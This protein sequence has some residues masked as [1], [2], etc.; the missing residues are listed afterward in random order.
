MA[1]LGISAYD[2]KGEFI[3]LSR[4]AGN[5][6]D[7]MKELTPEAR[8]AAMGVIFGSDAVRAANVLYEQ[9]AEGI[10]GWTDKVNS[11]GYA[12]NTAAIAQDN[13]AGDFEKL[14]GSLD[15][16]FLKSASGANGALRGLA[17][18]AEDLV[19]AIGKIPTPV[20]EAGLGI[21][22]VVGGAALLGGA[23]LTLAPRVIE[24]VGAFK[25]LADSGSK[26]P[27]M[28]GKIGKAAGLASVALIGLQVA[29]AIFTEKEV[30][31]TEEFGQALLKV[32]KAGQEIDKSGLDGAFQG[33][34]KTFGEEKVKNVNN[35][36]DAVDQLFNHSGYED[37]AKSFDGF[38]QMIGAGISP[39]GE[40]EN[41]F[42]GLGE[43]MGGLTR[44]G[45]ADTAAKSFALLSA[46][47]EKN[48]KT[49]QDALEK[50]PAYKDALL[51][52]ATAAGVTLDKYQLMDLAL[53]VIPEVMKG[54]T[55]ATEKYT[56]ASG[57]SQPV[58]EEM[59]KALAEVGLSAQGV[60]TNLDLLLESM[61]ATGLLTQSAAD[62][63][64]AYQDQLDELAVS[65]DKV[66]A[67]QSAGNLVLSE[68]TGSFDLTTD[69]GQA[70]NAVF[71]D[72][73]RSAIAT[74]EAMAKNGA[75]QPD[76]QAKLGSTF[77]SLKDTALGFG[78]SEQKADDLARSALGIPKGVPIETAINNY[79]DSMAKLQG[80]K[81]AVDRL[82]TFKD[83]SIRV[84]YTETG[85]AVRD[86]AGDA[87]MSNMVQAY[88]TGGR[89]PGFA[90]G[91]QLPTKGPGT[92]VTDGFLGI[93]S[94]G[95]PMARVDAGEW[96]IKRSSSDRYNRELAA[97]NA[98]TFPKLPG[99]AGGGR[100]YSAQSFGHAPYRSAATATNVTNNWN[101][102]EQSDPRV[103]AY[104]VSR[105]Q[106]SLAP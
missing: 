52:Q 105:R 76:L 59:S 43:A 82:P 17:Q 2:S 40:L 78:M 7:S 106:Q 11:A 88:A 21:A 14:T 77:Q 48:G 98:G 10:A 73:Q 22:G 74:T 70:A 71:G 19:V 80:L 58:T 1:E 62:A 49:S 55:E 87:G 64:S 81:E 32:S 3:G 83:L 29:S 18:G 44:N 34:D 37:F 95:I 5:L 47:F 20:L 8:N 4:F 45:G 23:F 54:A 42:K 75:S 35:M 86:R 6:K 15:S 69:A 85:T 101:I 66:K 60:I 92:D 9:G 90:D 38:N 65:I 103:T 79:A 13:L 46:E 99:Y 102:S 28:L 94:A 12:A 57:K 100:E 67:S 96:I 61:F 27:G 31:S 50:V 36:S 63:E 39:L 68:A 104:E 26:V 97:I 53:G 84:N 51:A 56:D 16:V 33:W 91:G 30:K 72:L 41:R 24:T 89:L 25:T 93:S